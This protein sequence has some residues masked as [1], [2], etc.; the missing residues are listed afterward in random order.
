MAFNR[1][2]SQFANYLDLDASANYI[3]IAD[4]SATEVGI[5]T[6][7]TDAKLT[8]EGDVKVSGVI[9]A[10]SFD[11]SFTGNADTATQLETARTISLGGDLSGSASF[12]GSSDITITGTIGANSV[13]LGTDTVGNYVATVADAGSGNITVSG[14]GSE[15]AAVTIDLADTGVSANTYGSTTKIPVVS[16]DAKRSCYQCNHLLALEQDLTVTGD[17]GSEDIDLLDE[18]LAISGGSNVTTTG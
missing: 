5:G 2:L 3:G 10:T 13:D 16:V 6:V 1:E 14:S 15:T 11:G 12:D 4:D 17:S 7:A 9:T 8:V 18:A